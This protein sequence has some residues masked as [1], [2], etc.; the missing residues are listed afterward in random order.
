MIKKL[1]GQLIAFKLEL[2]GKMIG[3]LM[4]TIFLEA[5]TKDLVMEEMEELTV[6]IAM[7]KQS[8]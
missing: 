8:E 1:N 4:E 6:F 3:L 5:V 7:V 2:F